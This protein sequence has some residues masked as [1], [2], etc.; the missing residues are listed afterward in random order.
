MITK[1][2]NITPDYSINNSVAIVGA[3][4]NLLSNNFGEFIDEFDNVIRFNRSPV[5][6]TYTKHTGTKTTLRAVNNHVFDNTDISQ[7]GYS[8]SPKN[9]VKKLRNQDILYIGPHEGPWERRH[10]NT[11]KSSRLFK[12]DYLSI[13]SLK[14]EIDIQS[15]QNL[16]IGT[17]MIALCVS[18][19]IVPHLFGFDLDLLPRTHYFEN[20]P[21][22]ENY[23]LHDP[24]EEKKAIRNLV[25][26][27]KV[28]AY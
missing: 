1:L 21:S 18:V 24:V 6:K 9:F 23:K 12:F 13:K 5:L 16:Q 10:Q 2:P 22:S 8:N 4:S 7:Q 27:K 20:R 3:S 28:V 25:E 14:K 19:N 11:H 15:E 17:I 26:S